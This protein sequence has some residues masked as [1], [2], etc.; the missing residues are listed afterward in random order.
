MNKNSDKNN[1]DIDNENTTNS[2]YIDYLNQILYYAL[3]PVNLY[4][5]E[6]LEKF[7]KENIIKKDSKLIN[8]LNEIK[9]YYIECVKDYINELDNSYN[10]KEKLQII[11]DNK[12]LLFI[13]EN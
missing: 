10:L 2:A 9:D 6:N 4:S 12:S 13:L 7:D 5:L 11:S 1:N 8:K 3:Y